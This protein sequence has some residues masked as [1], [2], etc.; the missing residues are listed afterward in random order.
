MEGVK[1]L[2]GTDFTLSPDRVEIGT[3]M[4]GAAITG[5]DITIKPVIFEHI[6]PLV[7]K[8]RE[9]GVNIK[10]EN[11]KILRVIAKKRPKNLR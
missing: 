6:I 10:I 3:F 11:G 8:L 4:I 9:I 7:F 5:G 2:H 1:K